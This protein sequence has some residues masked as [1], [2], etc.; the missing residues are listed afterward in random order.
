MRQALFLIITAFWSVMNVLLVRSEFGTGKEFAGEVPVAMVWQS[1]LEA[2]DDSSLAIQ[3]H[4]ERLGSVR[5][6]PVVGE[7][8][9]GGPLHRQVAAPD[10]MVSQRK[11][12]RIDAEG[13]FNTGPA[14]RLRFSWSV[15]LSTNHQWQEFTVRFG[16]RPATWQFKGHAISNTVELR[17]ESYDKTVWEQSMSLDAAGNPELWL[18]AAHLGSA[19]KTQ[20]ANRPLESLKALAEGSLAGGHGDKPL[21]ER[22]RW[23]AG[24]DWMRMGSSKVRVYRLEASLTP[25]LKA[26]VWISRVGEILKVSL[27]GEWSLINEAIEA[28]PGA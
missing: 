24:Q 10:G 18:A 21:W 3:V 15:T 4:G 27:P 22:M 19:N 14:S 13:H 28:L 12:Y 16:T 9:S 8:M 6:V 23:K 11:N 25:T 1:I 7:Q 5:W 20:A 26:A 2:P 17:H